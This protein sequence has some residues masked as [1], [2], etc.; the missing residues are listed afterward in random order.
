MVLY[1]LKFYEKFYKMSR[2][3]IPS[4]KL[5]ANYI[6]PIADKKQ[7]QIFRQYPLYE[8]ELNGDDFVMCESPFLSPVL[9][10]V[11]CIQLRV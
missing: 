3:H 2:C 4:T 11:V 7:G 9:G 5:C 8:L 10:W 6:L 1:K